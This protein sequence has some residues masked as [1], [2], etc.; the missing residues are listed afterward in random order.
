MVRKVCQVEF[1]KF[2]FGSIVIDRVT[3]AHDIVIDRG[4]ILKRNKK[5]SKQFREQFGHT[6][7]SVEEKLPWKCKRLV[8]GTGKYGSLPVMDEVRREARRRQ[9]ELTVVPTDEAIEIVVRNPKDTN[10]VLHVTC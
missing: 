4:E 6:P 10:A 9:I 7:V 8:V 5:P 2:Q 1:G 3:Y